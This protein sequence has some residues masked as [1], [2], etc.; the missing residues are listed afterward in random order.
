MEF[1]FSEHI[2]LENESALLK[3]MTEEDF[4]GLSKIAYDY[5]I[6]RFN[7]SR[8]MNDEEL[9]NYISSA[10]SHKKAGFAYPLVIIDKKT[11]KTAGSSSFGNIS[12]KDKRL[13]IGATWLGREFHGTG[14]NKICKFLMLQY[15]F[16]ELGIERVEFKTDVLNL[17]SRKALN[18]I[19]AAEEGILR[20]HTLMQDGRRR[21]TIYYS[22]LKPEWKNLKN[23][24]F[25]GLDFR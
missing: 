11:K 19:G 2:V 4:E 9:K 6:W 8:C 18:K 13:E 3:S 5:E 12:N 20:S 23:T 10:L 25:G 17:Q 14:L 15:A 7:V 21:D 22:I 1:S 16:E 24:I